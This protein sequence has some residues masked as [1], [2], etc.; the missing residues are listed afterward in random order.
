MVAAPETARILD[1]R[2]DSSRCGCACAGTAGREAGGFGEGVSQFQ[3][4]R[5]DSPQ[6]LGSLGSVTGESRNELSHRQETRHSVGAKNREKSQSALQS[7]RKPKPHGE[8]GDG[9]ASP[10]TS[11]FPSASPQFSYTPAHVSEQSHFGRPPRARSRNAIHV[12]R[13]SRRELHPCDR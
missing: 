1:L 13:P 5:R 2:R 11:V 7:L 8:A 10:I 6:K 12:E 3:K 4:L 9:R